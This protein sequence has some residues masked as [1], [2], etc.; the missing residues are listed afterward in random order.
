MKNLYFVENQGCDDRTC[1]LVE[2]DDSDFPRFKEFIENL[3]KNSYYGC[4]PTI[5]VSKVKAELFKEIVYNPDASWDDADYADSAAGG[6][7]GCGG[8]LRMAVFFHAA[9]QRQG[10]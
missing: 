7:S 3:N 6:G 10:G 9:A 1:G 2:I 4:M 5:C 8:L